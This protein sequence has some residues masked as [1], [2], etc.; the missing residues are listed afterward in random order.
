MLQ[1]YF[2]TLLLFYWWC[3]YLHVIILLCDLR[4]GLVA[5][6]MAGH[7][8]QPPKIIPMEMV[9]QVAKDKGYTAQG[10][11]F[12]GTRLIN[13]F[14]DFKTLISNA[15]MFCVFL[16]WISQWHGQAGRGSMRMQSSDFIRRHDGTQLCCHIETSLWWAAYSCTVSLFHTFS[17][18]L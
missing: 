1:I 17:L 6:W 14:L 12:S 16:F 5:L 4:C 2:C 7:L 9:V 10:E 15:I 11:M 3:L 13:M 18:F 8:L